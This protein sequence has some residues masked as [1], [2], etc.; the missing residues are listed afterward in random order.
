MQRVGSNVSQFRNVGA[1]I[2]HNLVHIILLLLRQ[3][4]VDFNHFGCVDPE[5]AVLGVGLLEKL[6]LLLKQN[7]ALIQ[8]VRLAIRNRVLALPSGPYA[9]CLFARQLNFVAVAVFQRQRVALLVFPRVPM[10]LFLNRPETLR[11]PACLDA[12]R[13]F[14]VEYRRPQLAQRPAQVLKEVGCRDISAPQHV[15]KG[16]VLQ[17][18]GAIPSFFL[19]HLLLLVHQFFQVPPFA[20]HENRVGVLD[21]MGKI[22]KH[23]VHR[24]QFVQRHALERMALLG[25]LHQ[26][27]H[28]LVGVGIIHALGHAAV[29]LGIQRRVCIRRRLHV[30]GLENLALVGEV[31]QNIRRSP[32]QGI[33]YM[34]GVAGRAQHGVQGFHPPD[35]LAP[36]RTPIGIVLDF[37]NTLVGLFP[38]PC[39]TLVGLFPQPCSTLVGLFPQPCSTPVSLFLCLPELFS[40]FPALGNSFCNALHFGRLKLTLRCRQ[41]V[42]CFPELCSPLGTFMHPIR[43]RLGLQVFYLLVRFRDTI[44][45]LVQLCGPFPAFVHLRGQ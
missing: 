30:F 22:L 37:C 35:D 16:V 36:Q 41:L 45:C 25:N 26:R 23:L 2:T 15:H 27:N 31:L 38:Q 11:R 14:S 33:R 39:S 10:V 5:G 24:H 28:A 19:K 34:P 44:L 17:C 40:P 29:F 42:F 21:D 4:F 7:A 13:S 1:E 3:P 6:F 18:E 20:V 9:H 8:M 32:A 43:Q 12:E